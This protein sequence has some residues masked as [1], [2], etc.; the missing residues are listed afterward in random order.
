VWQ[1]FEQHMK[2]PEQGESVVQRQAPF[3]QRL[4]L[5]PQVRPQLPQLLMSVA[6][7][8]QVPLQQV[9]PEPQVVP[10]APQFV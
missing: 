10:Q 1:P 7:A 2:K 8:R 4:L 3:V 5:L 9:C 6:S